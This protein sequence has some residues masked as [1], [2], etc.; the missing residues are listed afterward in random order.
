MKTVYVQTWARVKIQLNPETN[1]YE[2]VSAEHPSHEELTARLHDPGMIP[3]GENGE[4]L[5]K[6]TFEPYDPHSL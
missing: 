6:V 1:K 2:V 5:D 3:F 4:M